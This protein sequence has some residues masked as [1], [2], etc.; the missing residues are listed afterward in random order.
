MTWLYLPSTTSACAP[1]EEG[2]T[3]DWGWQFPLLARWYTWRGKPMPSRDWSRRCVPN[4]W[5]ADLCGA[6]PPP[7]EA[8]HGA[9]LWMASLAAS[10]ASRTATPGSACAPTTTETSG[11][12]RAA[13]SPR[14][15]HGGSSSRTSTG[16]STPTAP[17]AYAETFRD[18]ATRSEE[19][20]VGKEG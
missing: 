5:L 9:A 4:S 2:L 15:G 14:P 11:P 19:R 20:R 18:W 10:R 6:M 16:C 12:T 7:S 13:S 17:A 8:D 1:E 3:S